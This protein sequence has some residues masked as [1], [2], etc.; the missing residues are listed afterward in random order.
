VCKALQR[1]RHNQPQTD[2]DAKKAWRRFNK[3]AIRS[4]CY[5]QQLGLCAYTELSLDDEQLGCH[6][7]HIAPRSRYPERTFDMNNIVLAAMDECSSGLLKEEQRFGGHFKKA[8]YDDDWFIGPFDARCEHFFRYCKET[9]KVFAHHEISTADQVNTSRTI[10]VLNLN[11]D[12]LIGMRQQQLQHL[13]NVIHSLV[14]RES[15]SLIEQ[16]SKFEQLKEET[17]E[18]REKKLP[19]LYSAKK[20]LFDD[21]EKEYY[22]KSS[23]H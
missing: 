4:A 23:R 17:L 7:E 11:C 21:I 19:I 3:K 8:L 15:S 20:Q 2:I 10:A 22:Q 5:K 13:N 9:G 16:R 1:R 14:Q 6:L 12:Y 18:V